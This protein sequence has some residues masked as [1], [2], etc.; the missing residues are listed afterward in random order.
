MTH[1]L[2]F[3]SQADLV[4]VMEDGRVSESGSY[5]QLMERRGA[6]AKFINTFDRNRHKEPVMTREKSRKEESTN[7]EPKWK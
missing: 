5:Q 2:S 3:L 6:F 7:Q 4:L 1:G